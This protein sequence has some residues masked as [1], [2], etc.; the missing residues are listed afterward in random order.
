MAKAIDAT[1]AFGGGILLV[2]A[3]RGGQM[4]NFEVFKKRMTRPSEQ[5]VVTI[6]KRGVFSINKAAHTAIG[7]PKAVELLYD[8][9]E[10]IVGIRGV[11]ETVKHAYPLRTTQKT[12]DTTF[13]ASGLAF[14]KYYGIATETTTRW[15]AYVEDDIL[16]VDLKRGG[17][18]IVGNRNGGQR[19][20]EGPTRPQ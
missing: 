11:D 12:R 6:Q 18:E 5:P 9:E 1:R 7:S 17:T 10:R 20:E 16:C 2:L 15:D 4:P 13:M 14:T 3:E 19:R 8:P